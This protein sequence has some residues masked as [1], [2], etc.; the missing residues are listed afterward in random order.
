MH[1]P[2]NHKVHALGYDLPA[3][4]T[5]GVCALRGHHPFLPRPLP[6]SVTSI[7]FLFALSWKNNKFIWFGLSSILKESPV[8][9]A[10]V[11]LLD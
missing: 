4:A 9:P 10:V 2:V 5:S 1:N 8:V 11:W 7:P 3:W 6:F